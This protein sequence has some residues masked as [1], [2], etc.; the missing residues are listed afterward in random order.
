M[1]FLPFAFTLAL[2]R[3][4]GITRSASTQ[5]RKG[6]GFDDRPKLLLLC[7][8]RDINKMRKGNALS[9]NWRNSVPCTIRTSKQRSCNQKVGFCD[10][11]DLKPLELLNRLALGCYQPYPEV[12]R[13]C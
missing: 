13:Q 12:N 11:W 10:N 4:C 5:R 1:F 6:D 8:M 9:Q 2:A 3:V 7:Q